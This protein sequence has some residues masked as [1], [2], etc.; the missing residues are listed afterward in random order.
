MA[1]NHYWS[2]G[3]A[4]ASDILCLNWCLTYYTWREYIAMS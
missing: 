2:E 3:S 1:L 4:D